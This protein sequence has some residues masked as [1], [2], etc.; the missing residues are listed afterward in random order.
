MPQDIPFCYTLIHEE[1]KN[2]KRC[3]RKKRRERNYI[4]KSSLYKEEKKYTGKILDI[5]MQHFSIK[6]MQP[7]PQKPLH[8]PTPLNDI[9]LP[10]FVLTHQIFLIKEYFSLK[11]CVLKR[12]SFYIYIIINEFSI[13]HVT[14][15][16]SISISL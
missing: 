2:V 7:L 11:L 16:I 6:L 10:F 12:S 5:L 3:H 4:M 14:Q 8:T 15:F 13:F 1:K 9:I